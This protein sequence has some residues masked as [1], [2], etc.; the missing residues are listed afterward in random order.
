MKTLADIT[1]AFLAI[2]LLLPILLLIVILIV[3][4]DRMNPLFTQERI[5]RNKNP[6]VIIKFRTMKK[7]KITGFGKALRKTGIDELL[8]LI[9]ILKGE[10]SFVGPRP[11]TIEDVVRLQWGSKYYDQRWSMKPG[12]VG[13]AQ[14]SPICHKK[15]SWYLDR[16]YIHR[17]N[18][19]LDLKIITYSLLIP[20]VGK[21]Q[22]KKWLHNK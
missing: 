14:L 20:F 17:Q 2:I 3:V 10:M 19:M 18:F 12:I 8:Q 11:L 1:L 22:M 4:I 6:F 7:D 13:L 5:G 9:N 15:M 16:H 21:D